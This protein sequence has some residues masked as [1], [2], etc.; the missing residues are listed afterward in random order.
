M[1]RKAMAMVA[2]AT[3]AACTA[4]AQQYEE[5][6]YMEGQGPPEAQIGEAWCIYAYPAVY[7]DVS[8]QVMVRPSMT[9]MT[10]IPPQYGRQQETF[11]AVAEFP[12][13]KVVPAQFGPKDIPIEVCPAYTELTVIPA[14]FAPETIEIEVCP[15]YDELRW[16]P[17]TFRME[18]RS[19]V[20]TPERKELRK[21][22]CVDGTMIDCYT[23]VGAAAKVETVAIKV[24]DQPGYFEKVPVPAKKQM[25]TVNKLVEPA[26]AVERPVAAQAQM[27]RGAQL[28]KAAE[29]QTDVCPAQMG[30]VTSM[31]VL[32]EARVEM[33]KTDPVYTTQVRK[34]LVTPERVVWRKQRLS[35]PIAAAPIPMPAPQTEVVAESVTREFDYYGSTPGTGAVRN[36]KIVR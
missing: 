5:V 28:V 15:A 31:T 29:G 8:E 34:E 35:Q 21:V 3:L 9:T 32:Q 23:V 17:T 7:K 10:P 4:Y 6:P 33:K 20:I 27:I 22:A 1:L 24:V 25:V 36:T 26:R 30:T 18:N 13:G 16:V 12:V 2:A 14:K 11:T 19:F